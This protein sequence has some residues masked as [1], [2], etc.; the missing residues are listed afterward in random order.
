MDGM[1]QARFKSPHTRDNKK[2]EKNAKK[3]EKEMPLVLKN[4]KN[5]S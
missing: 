5:G 3:E 1:D 2:D 4:L